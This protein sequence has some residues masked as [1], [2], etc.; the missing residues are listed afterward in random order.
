MEK[1]I[2]FL[3]V[4]GVPTWRNHG[5]AE[6]LGDFKT[7]YTLQNRHGTQKMEFGRMI[8]LFKKGDFLRSILI[9]QGCLEF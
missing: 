7:C 3:D 1:R 2:I 5:F 8:F 6:M 4:D 9:F